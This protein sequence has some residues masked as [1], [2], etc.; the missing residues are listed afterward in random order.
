MKKKI[1][2]IGS[3]F[4]SLSAAC[5]LAK[6]GH[7]VTIFEKNNTIGGRARQ[8]TKD[9]F[10]FDIGPTWYWMPDVF[11]RFFADFNK[12]PS[13]FYQL[14][15][16]NPAYSVYYGK[17]DYI[18]I[19]DTL[20]KISIA[21]EKEEPG[22]SKTLQKFID[23]AQ[24]NYNVAIKD[25]VYNPGVSPFELV[26]TET[27]KKIGQF[28]STI[29]KDVRKEFKN[30]RLVTILEF[31]VLF[32]GA[33][34]GDTPSFYSFMNYADFGLGTFHPKKGM[35]QVIL[36]METLAKSLG[37]TIKT[38]API[39]KI[40]V[41]HKVASGVISNGETHLS[42]VVL[43]GADYHHTE[44]LLD[45][46]Y[47]QYSE[48]YWSSKTF[49]PSSLLFYVGFDKKIKNVNHHTLF[50]DVDFEKHAESIYDKPEWPENP[51]FY[52]S[53]PSITDTHAAPEGKE[54][55]I[56]LIPLAPGLKD[57]TK[58]RMTYFTKIMDRFEALTSQKVREHILFKE[59]F[60][61]NDFVKDYNSYKGNAYGMA[62][63]LLQ[64]AF[65]RPKLKSK[66]VNN[67]Y[68]TGQLTVP[69]PGVPPSLISGKLVA[70]LIIKHHT[71]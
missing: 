36:A 52:A 64:T 47:K 59:S 13:D 16:L 17:D 30:E 14:E 56:F 67:L 26:T 1:I 38:N 37:V 11:E 49:A 8:L 69:G 9:G 62:N 10:T 41:A 6:S 27:F 57:N 19:E 55:G 20:E 3:G 43:S 63:T 21:F 51:L 2:I 66:K 44:T 33:K 71:T 7:D 42:D 45:S 24:D 53:F 15:K 54:A 61:V 70:E 68:F 23:R 18:T 25:L 29:K 39:E 50:F 28:F 12:K 48:A 22:S 58:L 65:L 31:P 35:Y 32:L 40:L 34:P 4:S 5:Y 46:E 60:C